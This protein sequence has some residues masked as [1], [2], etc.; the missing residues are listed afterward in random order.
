MGL[1]SWLRRVVAGFFCADRD[2]IGA[3]AAED[4]SAPAA[5]KAV[6]AL[7]VAQA[8]RAEVELREALAAGEEGEVHIAALTSQLQESRHRASLHIHTYRERQ[9]QAAEDLQ[10]IGEIRRAEEINEERERLSRLL[11]RV[12]AL[13]DPEGL[14]QLEAEARA[15]AARLDVLDALSEGIEQP[16]PTV[17][18]T[19]HSD[20]RERARALLELEPFGDEFA[21]K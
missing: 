12:E 15:E 5:A 9:Q 13:T 16:L 3:P 2:D 14:E 10:T 4:Q 11:A 18:P 19:Q 8:L 6:A 1:L 20:A 7:A 17:T 21:G